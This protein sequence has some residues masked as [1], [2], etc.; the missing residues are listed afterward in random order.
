[1]HP[2]LR[3]TTRGFDVKLRL[4]A[5]RFQVRTIAPKRHC[6]EIRGSDAVAQAAPSV[7]RLRE[8]RSPV[9]SASPGVFP[10]FAQASESPQKLGRA[11]SREADSTEL[12]PPK[13]FSS[14]PR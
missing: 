1:M 7:Q 12:A 14:Q 13:N 6:R 8:P 10:G 11:V 2:P 9:P 5:M 4:L 3:R